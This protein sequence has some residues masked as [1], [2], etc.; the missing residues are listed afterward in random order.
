MVN[1][2]PYVVS[3][4]R[5]HVVAVIGF[6]VAMVDGYDTLMLAFIAPLIAK[7]WALLPQTVGALFASSY[8]GAALGATVIGIGADRFGRKTMLLASLALVG[9]FTMLCARSGNPTQLMAFR[10]LAGLGLGGALSTITALTAENASVERRRATVTRMF[11]GFPVGA[12]VGGA[13]TAAAMSYLG[14]RGVFLGG[15]VCAL[16]LLPLVAIGVS[17]SLRETGLAP[18]VHSRRPF[19][20][21]VSGGRARDTALFGVC[22][23]LMLLTSYF[24]VSWIPTVLTLNGMSPRRAAMGAVLLN[25]GGIVGSLILS[26]ILDR[27]NP[28]G[29][30]VGSLAA[31]AILIALLGYGILS[32]GGST[33]FLVFAVGLL[34]IGAQGGIP[35]LCVHL[36]PPSVYA[37]AVGLSV[38]CGRLGSIIGPLVGGYLVAAKLGWSRLFLLAALPALLASLT[39]WALAAVRR[40]DGQRQRL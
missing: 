29:P 8:A 17:E 7:E 11:L 31:G 18:H 40:N 28:L 3:R 36:Y 6:L 20:E 15:G 33:F 21:M 32:A 16:L 9:V 19:A 27:K 37:T 26:F 35:A 30:V 25:C 10:A 24:L 4:R 34:I 12:I 22:V 39:M 23:F 13:A 1:G 38:A 5:A 2:T 14:W